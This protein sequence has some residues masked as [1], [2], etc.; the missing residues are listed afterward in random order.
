MLDGPKPTPII[1]PWDFVSCCFLEDKDNSVGNS[2]KKYSFL[3]GLVSEP[4]QDDYA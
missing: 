3:L 4:A 1:R 2:E